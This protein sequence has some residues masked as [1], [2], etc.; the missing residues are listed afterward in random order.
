MNSFVYLVLMIANFSVSTIFTDHSNGYHGVIV[1]TG[2]FICLVHVNAAI[3]ALVSCA[4]LIRHKVRVILV[5]D[6][7][8]IT[9]WLK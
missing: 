8:R 3:H 5:N 2:R 1:G 7:H 9:W 4:N 6:A